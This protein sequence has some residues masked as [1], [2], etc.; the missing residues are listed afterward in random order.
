[1]QGLAAKWEPISAIDSMFGSITY[2]FGDDNLLVRMIG[3]RTLVIRFSGVVALR[4]EQECPGYDRLPESLP[5]LRPSETFPLLTIDG[6]QWLNQ[7]DQIYKGRRHF[8]LISSDH[9]VQLIANSDV[10]AQWENG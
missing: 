7:F 10:E 4:F 9:L 1:M 5:M 3:A 8:A 6:S 2:S